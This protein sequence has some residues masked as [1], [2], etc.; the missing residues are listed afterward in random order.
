MEPDGAR[1]TP[2]PP[3]DDAEI[4]ARGPMLAPVPVPAGSRRSR[5]RKRPRPRPTRA[6]RRR[7]PRGRS[8]GGRGRAGPP[9]GA[10]SGGARFSDRCCAP[11][12]RVRSAP[13]AEPAPDGAALH[14]P[15]LEMLAARE[16][17]VPDPP[18]RAVPLALFG[19]GIA[20]LVG[21]AGV[22]GA[23]QFGE[24]ERIIHAH[25]R[26]RRRRTT[27]ATS[28]P[29]RADPSPRRS[30]PSPARSPATRPP[31]LP[32]AD[33]PLSRAGRQ[34]SA[35]ASPL[36]TEWGSP[37]VLGVVEPARRLARR[38]GG[39]S[40]ATARSPG[41]AAGTRASTASNWSLHADLSKRDALSSAATALHRP[42]DA[43]RDRPPLRTPRPRAA[44]P[45]PTSSV[46]TDP[47]SPYGCCVL[48]LSGHQTNLPCVLARGRPPGGARHE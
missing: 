38:A 21:A 32:Q 17:E 27:P 19:V 15:V 29:P 45:S 34:E 44:S 35:S 43:R 1:L 6:R 20:S 7:L 30:R 11:R 23:T 41:S 3:P 39:P 10:R 9:G 18:R 40:S 46:V 4:T 8:G 16:R 22:V 33:G 13:A 14:H 48:A 12:E 26:R 37:R 31:Y 47:D 36:S 42:Q 2:V 24:T 28:S 25:G 5:R